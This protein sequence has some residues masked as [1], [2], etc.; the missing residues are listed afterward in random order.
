MLIFL[1][2]VAFL[3]SE[4]PLGQPILGCLVLS[5]PRLTLVSWIMYLVIACGFYVLTMCKLARSMN[6][7]HWFNIKLIFSRAPTYPL[8]TVFFLDGNLFFGVTFLVILLNTVVDLLGGPLRAL[9]GP[10]LSAVYTVAGSRLVL[11]LRTK[12]ATPEPTF[13]MYSFSTQIT[14]PHS[15][16]PSGFETNPILLQGTGRDETFVARQVLHDDRAPES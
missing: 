8:M 2:T 5:V 15:G 1:L 6:L 11:N 3:E 12:N 4:R 16:E 9:G 10:W 7:A 13:D 14:Q